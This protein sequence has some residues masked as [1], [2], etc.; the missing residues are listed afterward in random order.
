M[1]AQYK[2]ISKI[3]TG[4]VWRYFKGKKE[5]SGKR[6]GNDT[7][8]TLEWTKPGFNDTSWLEKVSIGYGDDDDATIVNDMHMK[9]MSLYLHVHHR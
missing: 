9:Y 4:R 6:V 1:S 3:Q 5:P 2:D 7:I 8:A